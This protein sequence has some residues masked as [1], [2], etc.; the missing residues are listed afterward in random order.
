MTTPWGARLLPLLILDRSEHSQDVRSEF[1]F[2]PTATHL[3]PEVGKIAALMSE[4][5]SLGSTPHALPFR[6]AQGALGATM[7]LLLF[8]GLVTT[9]GA[10]MAVAGWI[11]AEGHFL[12]LFPFAKWFRDIPTFAEHTHRMVGVVVGLLLIAM[13]IATFVK[14]CRLSARAFAIAAL[15][16]T[17][18]Q[19]VV[20]G[21]RVLENSQ[22]LAFLHGALAQAVFCLIWC[23][24]L[25]LM[26]SYQ[27]GGT[28]TPA[29]ASRLISVGS[30]VTVI[31]YGQIILGAWFR[32]SI[33][34]ATTMPSTGETVFPM[35]AFI[36]HAMGAVIV[37]GA[38]LV[39]AKSVRVAW[40]SST[41][42]IMRRILQRQEKW[43]HLCFGMQFLLGLGSLSTLGLE[44]TAI[45]VVILTTLHVLFG[46]LT[47]SAAAGS[48]LWGRR[49]EVEKPD[50]SLPSAA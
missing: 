42:E 26:P 49:L 8:G 40:E 24:T 44:R 1:V 3:G 10:G 36:A 6:L 27:R 32:H 17:V 20:G 9:I 45:P 39:L 15:L 16:A 7:V 50:S 25:F 14:D 47:L 38:V 33:R 31:I 43:L 12:P 11:D 19:G 21:T 4:T 5:N 2:L 35:G 13:V 30:T 48:S 28:S 41:D 23:T 18:G 22:N 34:H 46:A 29:A 37:A